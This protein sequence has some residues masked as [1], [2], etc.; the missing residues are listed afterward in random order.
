MVLS[1][2]AVLLLLLL[3]G[4]GRIAAYGFLVDE[5]LVDIMVCPQSICNIKINSKMLATLYAGKRRRRRAAR[6]GGGGGGA[7]RGLFVNADRRSGSEPQADR[8]T[9]STLP[10]DDSDQNN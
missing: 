7:G 8:V 6:G 2:G 5:P 10:G 9:R 4:A 3:L 1:L